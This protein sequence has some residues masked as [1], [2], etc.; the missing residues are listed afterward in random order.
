MFGAFCY[1][2]LYIVLGALR[3]LRVLRWRVEGLAQLPPREQGGMIIAMNHI[4][5]VDTLAIGA[6][7]PFSYRLSW[8][9]K[10][11]LFANPVVAWWFRQM[12]AIPVRRGKRDLQAMDAVVAAVKA[13]AVMLIFP[14]G[15]RSRT[16]VLQEGRGGALRLAMQAGVPIVPLAINGTQHGFGRKPV[17]LR[18]G[19]P[20]VVAPTPNGKVPPEQMEQLTNELMHRIASMLPLEQRGPYGPFLAEGEVRSQEGEVRR[21]KI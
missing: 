8:F 15:T 5:W 9:A 7:L 6:L 3:W 21:K 11:E 13:G 10:S 2:V 12:N 18:I 14:E 17:L 16:G 19:E 4:S 1:G 20:Y